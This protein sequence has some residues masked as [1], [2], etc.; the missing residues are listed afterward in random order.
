MR[1]LVTE[2]HDDAAQPVTRQLLDAG[3]EVVRCREPDGPAFPCVG[4]EPHGCPIEGGVDV[5]L[6]VR[7]GPP[8]EPTAR[9]DGAV[10]ALRRH[11]PLVVAGASG[12]NPFAGWAT[13]TVG[14][15]DVVAACEAAAAA[16]VARLSE[17]ARAETRRFLEKRG[18]P[19]DGV[20]VRTRRSAHEL[21]VE[22]DLPGGLT[23]PEADAVAV[24]VADA[25]RAA[26]PTIP[27]IDVRRTSA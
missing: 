11:V 27:V 16:D 22:L 26:E 5:A 12:P 8:A 25:V 21:K 20:E 14:D 15:G 9:E 1:I 18:H 23:G 2:T 3:H 4:L 19:V 13:V 10:C 6:T 17:V 24:S 7:T